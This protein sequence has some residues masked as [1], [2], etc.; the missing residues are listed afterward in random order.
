MCHRFSEEGNIFQEEEAGEE[1][2][3]IEEEETA[4]AHAVTSCT[5]TEEYNC[6]AVSGLQHSV[7]AQCSA[8]RIDFVQ[9][10]GAYRGVP[11]RMVY[12]YYISCLRYTILAGSP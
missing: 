4:E 12:L 6:S 2:E 7:V 3:E 9:L 8:L 5:R 10:S 11:T 1:E